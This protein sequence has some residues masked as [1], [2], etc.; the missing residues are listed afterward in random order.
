MSVIFALHLEKRLTVAANGAFFG[1]RLAVMLVSALKANPQNGMLFI[2]Y[3]SVLHVFYKLTVALLVLF[4]NLAHFAEKTRDFRKTFRLCLFG[5]TRVH[6]RPFV[7]FSVCRVLEVIRSVGQRA[8]GKNFKPDFGVLVFVAGSFVK[9]IAYLLISVLACF[10][11]IKSVFY[12]RH[13]FRRKR[14]HQISLGLGVL[15]VFH[16]ITPLL[17]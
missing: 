6:I 7:P 10:V 1:R 13:A 12:A 4:F 2:E 8:A 17:N 9:N 5:V 3:G 14:R 15:K 11:C 16:K